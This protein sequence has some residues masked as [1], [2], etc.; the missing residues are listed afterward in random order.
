MKAN[1]TTELKIGT[2]FVG[3]YALWAILWLINSYLFKGSLFESYKPLPNIETE[4]LGFSSDF[5]LGTDIYGRSLLEVL[6]EGLSYTFMT[7][8]TVSFLSAVI[9]IF[10]G[11]LAT[12]DNKMIK[13]SFDLLINVIFIFPTILVAILI[14]SLVG[15]SYWGLIF[16]LVVTGW[17]GYA[18]IARG[19]I[20]RIMGMDYVEGAKAVG[21]S[22]F[23]LFFSAIFPNLLPFIVIHF[24]LGL[25]GVIIS[26]ATLGFLG[27]GG[28]EYSWGA[29]LSIAKNVLLEA[30]RITVILSICIAGIIIGLNLLG[31]GL[32]D[33]LDPHQQ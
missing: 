30:P 4:L 7:S 24:V 12:I 8:L 27:L 9:G 32:R 5:F 14:M 23:R 22:R 25:S 13:T 19:E 21:A 26:E 11:Y 28:S 10:I 15:Q 29:L 18:K 2:Y 17:P 33:Y 31:D 1:K 16:A 3:F 20:L 6:S